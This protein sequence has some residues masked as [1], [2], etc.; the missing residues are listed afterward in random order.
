[1]K[2]FTTYFNWL[3]TYPK[4]N[5]KGD[6]VAG[7]TVGILLIPQGMA[8]AIIAGLPVVYGLYAAIFPQI[9]YFFLGSSKRLAVGPVALDSLIV[10][11]GLGAL[12]LD[13]TLYV[14]A[15]ILLALLVGSIHFLLGIFKL[16]FLVN[17]LSKPVISGFTL[18]AAITIGF[19]QLKY[20]LGT[21]RIDNSNNLRLLNFNTF[22]ESIHLPTFLLG[23]GTLLLLVLFK[24]MNKNI[25][26]PIIIVVLGLL[27][28]YF[29]NLKELGISIIGHIPSGLPSFQYPQLSYELVLKLIPIAITLAIISYTEAI[30][31]A[32][33]I[34]A[35][36]EENELKPNQELI[37]LGFLNI[38]GAFFQ[39]YPVT[40]G[41]SRTIV[42]DD[43]G[44]NS[45]IASLI[46][47]F[48]VAIV[49]V[50]LTPLFYYLPKA[51]LGAII[52]VSVL[53]LL[54][55]NYAIELFKNRKDEFLVLLVSFI[56]S[57][58][59]GIK[60]GL[61]FGVLLS[62]LLMVYRTSKPHIAVLGNVKGT[63]YFKNITRF[64]EQIDTHNSILILRFDA[65]IYF[66]NAAFFRKQILKT[67][68]QQQYTID[69]IVLNAE[70]ISYIDS[71][72]VYM[73]KSL[74]KEL[75]NKGV[76]LVVSSAIGP[77]RDIF[78][79]TGLLNEIGCDNLFI[80]TL[81][82]YEFLTKKKLQTDLQSKISLQSNK[83]N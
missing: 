69:T 42:N 40:G 5:L 37:A 54:N 67:L 61:L 81:A 20:I 43:S 26:S 21:Y 83:K 63:P 70:S 79:K 29:L 72:G 51:I 82:A 56:F 31:I 77:I 12:N 6:I 76:R 1:M 74:I 35:K 48:T 57:L 18:A 10:A 8:Y 53:G 71:S 15:A 28:S 58:F 27:V 25:P 78:N 22:W 60:Q 62:L 50:F 45:K 47:A 80:D 19:S 39:S 17:F 66:G 9:I 4:S 64:S 3:T 7:I 32:K 13:T 33:V 65:Q 23:F 11:A 46:S 16:G 75:K 73:L 55:F 44:A 49:L 14:Q 52:I 41:L 38:I 59:M 24:K 2:S 68:E 34:E 30:S 36:H